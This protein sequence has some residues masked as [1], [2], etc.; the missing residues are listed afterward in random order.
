IIAFVVVALIAISFMSFKSESIELNKQVLQEK[1]AAIEAN[2]SRRV[3]GYR[4]V[5]SGVKASKSD[6]T[7]DGLSDRAIIQLEMLHRTQT[8]FIEG[9]YLIDIEGGVYNTKGEK[10]D[11]NVRDLERNYYKAVFN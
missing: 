11:F 10:L 4:S 8:Q 1:N 2:L 9:A 3:E 5:L 7:A 6:I